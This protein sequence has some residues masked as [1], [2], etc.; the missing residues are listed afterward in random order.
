MTARMGAALLSL[1][2]FFVALYLW[3]YKQGKIG[4]LACGSGGCESVQLSPWSAVLGVDVALIG[5]VGYAVLLGIAL[6]GLQP[7]HAGRRWPAQWI[8]WL[9]L[10]GVL[11]AVYLTWL[12]VFVI[13]AICRWCVAS[14]VIITLTC[15]AAWLDLRR[16]RGTGG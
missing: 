12:E 4:A 10:G 13:H 8:F 5:M 6:V 16:L 15:V 14:A 3:L 1:S 7:A 2:G 9:S 11:F